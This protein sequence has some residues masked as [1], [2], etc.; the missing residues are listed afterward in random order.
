MRSLFPAFSIKA[1]NIFRH[2]HSS[3]HVNPKLALQNQSILST[4]PTTLRFN[5]DEYYRSARTCNHRGMMHFTHI[6]R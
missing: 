6:L 2:Y 1:A 4:I 3:N 5:M